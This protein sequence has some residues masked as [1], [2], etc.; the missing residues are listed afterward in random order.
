LSPGGLLELLFLLI[1][2]QQTI[3]ITLEGD[4]QEDERE[5]TANSD[6]KVSKSAR[7]TAITRI[8]GR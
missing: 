4:D 3:S 5:H 7:G 1:L 8:V 6:R 2:H